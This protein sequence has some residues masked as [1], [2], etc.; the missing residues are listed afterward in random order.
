MRFLFVTVSVAAGLKLVVISAVLAT[1]LASSSSM[2]KKVGWVSRSCR[3]QDNSIN[4]SKTGS[5]LAFDQLST[6]LRHAHDKHT[7]VCDQVGDLVCDWT[8]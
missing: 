6:G 8:A 7:Q 4:K 2:V 5:Q 3:T 1:I